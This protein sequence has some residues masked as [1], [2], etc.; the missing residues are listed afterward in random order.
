M[1]IVNPNLRGK[2]SAELS[3]KDFPH[4]FTEDGRQTRKTYIYMLFNDIV[5]ESTE[6]AEEIKRKTE[7]YI[8]H[9]IECLRAEILTKNQTIKELKS[10]I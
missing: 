6:S 5:I 1:I 9:K 7:E 10:M 2:K 8:K 3:K 4:L